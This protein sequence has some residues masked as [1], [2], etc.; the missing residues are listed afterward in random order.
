MLD[1]GA[2]LVA[3]DGE[4]PKL[5]QKNGAMYCFLL[6]GLT[7]KLAYALIQPWGQAIGSRIGG[8]IDR[9]N[10]SYKDNCRGP[11]GKAAGEAWRRIILRMMVRGQLH[12]NVLL[13]SESLFHSEEA[14]IAAVMAGGPTMPLTAQGPAAKPKDVATVIILGMAMALAPELALYFLVPGGLVAAL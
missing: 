2:K 6:E 10:Q 8:L 4:A 1:T 12:R 5:F 3:V 11:G 14:A 9:I 13:P 7:N